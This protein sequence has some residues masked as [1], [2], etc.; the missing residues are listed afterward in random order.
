LVEAYDR[1]RADIQP[2]ARQR[3]EAEHGAVDD[4]GWSEE[5]ARH[6]AKPVRAGF[7]QLI[8]DKGF[9]LT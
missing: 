6:Y 5:K 7:G 8:R 3:D 1:R 2:Y 4:Y 9:R